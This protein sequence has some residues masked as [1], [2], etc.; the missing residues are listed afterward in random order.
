MWKRLFGYAALITPVL[1]LLGDYE[2]ANFKWVSSVIE[3]YVFSIFLSG[4][5]TMILHKRREAK[6][7]ALVQQIMVRERSMRQSF[8]AGQDWEGGN[9]LEKKQEVLYYTTPLVAGSAFLHGDF[10]D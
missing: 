1:L 9:Q 8:D 7:D 4:I 2:F 6:A 5:V 3:A 10:C